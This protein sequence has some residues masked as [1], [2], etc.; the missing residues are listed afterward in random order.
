M[1]KYIKYNLFK[2]FA[3]LVVA[4]FALTSCEQTEPD[5]RTNTNVKP[6]VS[7]SQSSYM[8]DEGKDLEITLVTNTPLNEDMLFRLDII[9]EGSS[10]T[11]FDDY[12]LSL[13]HTTIESGT[14]DAYR[15]E[16]PKYQ[17]SYTFTISAFEDFMFDPSETIKFRLSSMGYLNGDVAASSEE[18]V[19]T[20][21][22]SDDLLTFIFEWDQTFQ[23]SGSDYTLCD[24]GYDNDFVYADSNFNLIDYIAGTADCPEIGQLSL[25]EL[26]D[27][28]FHIFQNVWDD[29]NLS[30]VNI[31]PAFSI[32]V[33]T[34]FMKG[35]TLNGSYVQDAANAVDSDFG[36]DPNLN[37]PVYVVSFNISGTTVTMYDATTSTTIASGRSVKPQ[38][39]GLD[40]L[41]RRVK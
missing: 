33:T 41:K 2:T 1:R 9:A 22:Q 26:G 4:S 15:V 39:K 32:P 24:I 16:F 5:Y 21:N 3:L 31:A 6:V 36:S 8:V 27:G 19:V 29:G 28:D 23:F 13:D 7:F 12:E 38:L 20:I 17:N 34:T 10:A 35:N 25:S 30:S 14:E 40:K 11:E 37:S 18:V